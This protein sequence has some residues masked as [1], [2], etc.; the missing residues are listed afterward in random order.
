MDYPY[1][2]SDKFSD[3]SKLYAVINGANRT[4]QNAWARGYKYIQIGNGVWGET[5]CV[6]H[7]D[8]IC[9][10]PN[11]SIIK[12]KT[13]E[14]LNALNRLTPLSYFVS[15]SDK[16]GHLTTVSDVQKAVATA[17]LRGPYLLF[18]HSLP[19]HF[20]Y[21]SR[22]DCS[23][24]PVIQFNL[25]GGLDPEKYLEALQCVNRRLLAFVEYIDKHDPKAIV[26]FHSDHGSRFLTDWTQPLDAWTE[27]QFNER[28][29]ILFA[30]RAPGRCI[31]GLPGNFTLVNLFRF[32]FACLDARVPEYLENRHFIVTDS[33]FK[34]FGRVYLYPAR[35]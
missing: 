4:I 9:R 31:E 16:F 30:V 23:D 12:N 25:S 26:I 20:P 1:S 35:N 14:V 8:I 21:T 19:P 22:A 24:Q 7:P 13:L 33:G 10:T 6:E 27:S 2:E 15:I 11:P 18:A 29:G 17:S 28:F 34:D 5:Q 32:V 3:Y